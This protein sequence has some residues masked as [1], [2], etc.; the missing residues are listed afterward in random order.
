M[1]FRVVAVD[2]DGT[3]LRSDKSISARTRSALAGCADGGARVVI[4]TARPPR[5]VQALAGGAGIGGLAI[6]SNGA[7]VHDLGTD[8]FDLVGPLPIAVAE[9]AADRIAEVM[10]GAA[11]AVETGRRAFIGPGYGHVATR[12]NARVE[13]ADLWFMTGDCA[14]LLAWSPAP[15]TDAL[16]AAVQARV[17][18]VAVSYSGANG[19]IE[20]SAAA[21]SKVDTLAR[22]CRSWG[23]DA[24]DVIAFGDAPNDL[25]MLQWAGTAVAV[26]NAH[27]SVLAC[28]GIVTGSNDDDG[29]AAVLEN[30]FV[31][32]GR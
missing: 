17:P 11:F 4:V 27:P 24:A 12:D 30:E 8:T 28:T 18:E 22:L 7:I 5:F 32:P 3:L 21:V 23:V 1:G 19:M 16:V 14:K 13:V 29:V 6:C 20:I 15:V 9:R 31:V 10:P 25:S 2:L 26:A